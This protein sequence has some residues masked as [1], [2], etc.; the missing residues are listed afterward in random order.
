MDNKILN[1]II[2]IINS[3]YTWL[4]ECHIQGVHEWIIYSNMTQKIIWT[5]RVQYSCVIC[6]IIFHVCFQ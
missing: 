5:M 2:L 6:H 3:D 4:Q 1:G